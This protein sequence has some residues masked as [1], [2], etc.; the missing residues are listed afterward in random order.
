MSVLL[1]F[2]LGS[3]LLCQCV[4][5][6]LIFLFLYSFIVDEVNYLNSQTFLL[7]YLFVCLFV[8]VQHRV[9]LCTLVCSGTHFVD[10]TG[11]RL[12]ELHLPLLP[13]AGIKGMH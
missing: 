9:S 7:H 4:Q 8:V 5:V 2:Y 3:G 12:T 1:G 11:L 13:N 10:K 6:H